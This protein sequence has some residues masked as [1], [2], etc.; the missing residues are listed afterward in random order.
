MVDGGRFGKKEI[1]SITGTDT[2]TTF[3]ASGRAVNV[4]FGKE[5]VNLMSL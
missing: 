2:K 4:C 3:V 5:L 1:R